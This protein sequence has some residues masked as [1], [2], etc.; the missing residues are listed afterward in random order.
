MKTKRNWTKAIVWSTMLLI[1]ALIWTL[2][3][4]YIIL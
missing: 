3:F 1:T 4:K 2:I